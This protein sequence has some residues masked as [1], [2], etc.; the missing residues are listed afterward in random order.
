MLVDV[1]RSQQTSVFP[2]EEI[3]TKCD[4][5]GLK[6]ARNEQI[7]IDLGRHLFRC[8]CNVSCH[9]GVELPD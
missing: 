9:V 7:P 2:C 3:R 5:S 8:I 1:N 4:I 6:I